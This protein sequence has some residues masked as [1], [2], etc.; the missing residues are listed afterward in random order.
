MTISDGPFLTGTDH[1]YMSKGQVTL[2]SSCCTCTLDYLKHHIKF[3]TLYV[4]LSLAE[5]FSPRTTLSI[6][7]VI[8]SSHLYHL[9]YK[10]TESENN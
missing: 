1:N 5:I 6:L 8:Y 2:G 9:V 7:C 10:T 3:S 4:T